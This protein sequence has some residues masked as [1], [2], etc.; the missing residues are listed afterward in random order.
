MANQITLRIEPLGWE[1]LRKSSGRTR[2]K[3][4]VGVTTTV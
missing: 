3:S 2:M 4:Q 1:S